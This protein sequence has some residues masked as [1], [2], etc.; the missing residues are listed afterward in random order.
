M[1]GRL[2]IINKGFLWPI[3]MLL[4]VFSTPANAEDIEERNCSAIYEDENGDLDYYNLSGISFLEETKRENFG[5]D[6]PESFQALMCWR[7]TIV[8]AANDY[9]ITLE[10]FP[11]YIVT[12]SESEGLKTLELGMVKGQFIV[13]MIEG[14]L[15]PEEMDAAQ[16]RL[17]EFQDIVQQEK[18]E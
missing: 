13:E 11:F 9:K 16:I 17:N 10:G 15:T 2:M 3:F 6:F 7:S 14:Q 1:K 4:L 18:T 12:G 5:L 8:P